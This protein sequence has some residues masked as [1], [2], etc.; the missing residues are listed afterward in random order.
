MALWNSVYETGNEKVD[1]DHKEIFG[2]VEQVLA[3]SFKSR[4]EKVQTAIE[5]LSSYVVRHFATEEEL[6][7]ESDY[8][9]TETHK[10]EHSDFL[11]VATKLHEKFVN[12]GF[13]L[14][15]DDADA[16][17]LSQEINKTVIGWL[18][19]HVMGSDRALADH[20]RQWSE[21]NA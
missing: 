15:E 4:K 17:H 6:M 21:K 8:P 11:V 19:K 13:S 10:K 5:F 20:Y 1:N 3:T 9:H 12:D 7:D 14:G 18:T 16:L 2:L